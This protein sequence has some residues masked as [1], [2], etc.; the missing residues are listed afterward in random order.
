MKVKI[1]TDIFLDSF[2]EEEIDLLWHTIEGKHDWIIEDSD[3]YETIIQ[4]SWY[5]NISLTKKKAIDD[6]MTFAL[7]MS[8]SHQIVISNSSTDYFSIREAIKYLEQPFSLIIENKLNDAPFF[9]SLI[10]HFPKQ[11]EKIKKHKA[12]RWFKYDMGGGSTIIHNLRAEMRSFEGAIYKKHASEYLR[13][14]V[15]IDSDRSFPNDELKIE[16]KMLIDFLNRCK[17][18]FHILEKREME[19]YL[20]DEAFSEIA[21]N[22]EFV[23]AFLNLS[24]VQKDYFDLEKGFVDKRFE[25]F[26]GEIQELYL[27]VPD[28]DRTIFRKQA[29]ASINGNEDNFKSDFPKLFQT[30]KVNRENLLAR[31]AHHSNDSNIHPYNPNELPEL[32]IQISSLL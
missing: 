3:T 12:E 13:C 21:D 4:S 26:R 20:P 24:P 2:L 32:L 17:I 28:K 8:K 25:Q 22:R 1:L 27:S 23:D 7:Q 9:D 6:F 16:T 19:N 14:F 18:S 11:S 10:K 15:L 5:S 30:V 31:C 29:L